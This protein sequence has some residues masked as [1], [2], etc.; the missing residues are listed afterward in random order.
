[1]RTSA[2]DAPATDAE[3]TGPDTPVRRRRPGGRPVDAAVVAGF[4]A[5]AALATFTNAPGEVIAD[6]RLEH[7]TEPAQFL[8]RHADI[9]DDQRTLGEPTKYF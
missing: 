6:A 9:W 2:S 4:A 8:A 1:M 7:F 3:P 5:L